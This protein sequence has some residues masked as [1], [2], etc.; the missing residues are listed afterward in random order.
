MPFFVVVVDV[1][2]VIAQFVC[3]ISEKRRRRLVRE[4]KKNIY[5]RHT[6]YII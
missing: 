6:V 1:V 3:I 4:N 5:I 2:E